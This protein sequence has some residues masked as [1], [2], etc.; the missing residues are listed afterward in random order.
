MKVPVYSYPVSNNTCRKKTTVPQRN[1]CSPAVCRIRDATSIF[2]TDAHALRPVIRPAGKEKPLR[3]T[4]NKNSAAYFSQSPNLMISGISRTFFPPRVDT[5]VAPWRHYDA[6]QKA[7]PF[8]RE[9]TVRGR[10]RQQ[11]SHRNRKARAPVKNDSVRKI[12]VEQNQGAFHPCPKHI[13]GSLAA[14]V[15]RL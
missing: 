14:F 8:D 13:T 1:R 11:V 2:S 7:H 10:P 9:N 4:K 12:G 5:P 3:C 6:R 15:S